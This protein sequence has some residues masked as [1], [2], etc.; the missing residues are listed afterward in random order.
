MKVSKKSTLM[1]PADY[2]KIGKEEA[3]GIEGGIG[4]VTYTEGAYDT[5]QNASEITKKWEGFFE[6]IFNLDYR[7]RQ[8]VNKSFGL[9]GFFQSILRAFNP[10]A[11]VKSINA[12]PVATGVVNALGEIGLERM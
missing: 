6:R 3:Y 2:G 4:P 7:Q 10:T 1:F 11:H 9:I 8:T 12:A 5:Y